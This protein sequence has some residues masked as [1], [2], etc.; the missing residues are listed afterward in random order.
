MPNGKF[1]NRKNLCPAIQDGASVILRS[2]EKGAH[3]ANSN[4]FW[5]ANHLLALTR[6]HAVA[7][8]D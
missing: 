8:H 5:L 1:M 3:C 2:T 4:P 6:R 7:F